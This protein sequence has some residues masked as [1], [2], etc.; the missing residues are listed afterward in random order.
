MADSNVSTTFSRWHSRCRNAFTLIELLVSFAVFSLIMALV[1]SVIGQT[2]LILR[3][4][5]NDM[6]SFQS[7]RQAFDILTRS[8]GQATL[9]SY[10]DYQF[11]SGQPA[12]YRRNSDL[13][14]VLGPAGVDGLP[15]TP[16]CGQAVFFQALLGKIGVGQTSIGVQQLLNEIGFYVEF[17][18]NRDYLPSLLA[19]QLQEKYRYRLFQSIKPTSQLDIYT[20]SSGQSWIDTANAQPVADNVIALVLIPSRASAEEARL[21]PLVTEFKYDSRLNASDRPQPVTAHQL[22][23]FCA[24][25]LIAID[26][27][28]ATRLDKGSAA[29]TAIAQALS[30][31]FKDLSQLEDD[32]RDLI[33]ELR[34]AGVVARVFSIRLPMRE[35][36]WSEF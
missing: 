19:A 22:P 5:T 16:G 1:L 17:G 14:F 12:R 2:S 4:S 33:T 21:G 3:R 29:P 13:N 30:E 23:P 6:G 15:G 7:A 32:L 25:Y 26:E 20:T 27:D 28:S 8:V 36:K 9:G 35:S 11:T 31:K 34:D 18:S 24:T 10:W